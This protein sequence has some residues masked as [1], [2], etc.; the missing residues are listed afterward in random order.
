[1][2]LPQYPVLFG[3]LPPEQQAEGL[4]LLRAA[5]EEQFPEYAEVISDEDLSREMAGFDLRLVMDQE[6]LEC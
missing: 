4:K 2:M 1:M 5:I 6:G 3:S